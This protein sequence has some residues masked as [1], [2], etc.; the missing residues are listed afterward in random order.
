MRVPGCVF[1]VVFRVAARMR[2]PGSATFSQ[3]DLYETDE[4]KVVFMKLNYS[5][6]SSPLPLS[7]PKRDSFVPSP[8][9]A[10]A[11]AHLHS[12]PALVPLLQHNI[13]HTCHLDVIL[14]SPIPPFP[15][16]QLPI[17]LTPSMLQ[18]FP[19]F[20]SLLC[21]LGIESFSYGCSCPL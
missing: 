10:G 11:T 3:L 12:L 13:Y 15:Q 18:K 17:F 2:V 20:T 1:R 5:T 19:F 7:P 9:S 8:L 16:V 14:S 21:W 4:T 6:D